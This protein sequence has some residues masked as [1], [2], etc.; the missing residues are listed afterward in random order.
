MAFRLSASTKNDKFARS[1][2]NRFGDGGTSYSMVSD[3]RDQ[4]WRA[5]RA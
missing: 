1:P 5:L 3:P 4:T 2:P